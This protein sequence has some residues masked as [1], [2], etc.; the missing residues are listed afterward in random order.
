MKHIKLFLSFLLAVVYVFL[1]KH[2][3][4]NAEGLLALTVVSPDIRRSHLQV[5]LDYVAKKY[6][7]TQLS[8]MDIKPYNVRLLQDMKNTVTQ[9]KFDPRKGY[10]GVNANLAQNELLL[11]DRKIFFPRAWRLATR[12]IDANAQLGP[13][14]TYE[15][16]LHH[17]DTGEAVCLHSLYNGVISL[18]TG[19]TSRVTNL[20]NDCFRTV[21]NSVKTE[22]AGAVTKWPQY[23]PELTDRGYA[24]LVPTPVLNSTETN[25]IVVDLKGK[26][27]QIEGAANKKN[28]L[29]LDMDGWIF[30]LNG[31]NNG[32][33]GV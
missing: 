22:N 25:L 26:V 30:D 19:S 29:Q 9:Y 4:D 8:E 1:I 20:S 11:D 10:T 14:F 13:I 12:K 6:G 24:Y 17:A 18:T 7:L 5:L 2:G 33:C 3:V 32:L 31:S 27:D 23:G 15:D 16:I 28:I 21:P